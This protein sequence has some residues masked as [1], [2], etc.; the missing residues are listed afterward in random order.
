M[1]EGQDDRILVFKFF[2]SFHLCTCVLQ[3][4]SL[5]T[6]VG[7]GS[8]MYVFVVL[9][10]IF[11]GLSVLTSVLMLI[12]LCVEIRFLL[13]PWVISVALTT[14]LDVLLS[15]CII[16]DAINDT[17]TVIFFVVD[18]IVCALNIYC[19]LCVISQYQELTAGRGRSHTV[20][21]IQDRVAVQYRHDGKVGYMKP[22]QTNGPNS[23]V[24]LTVPTGLT[25]GSRQSTDMSSISEELLSSRR[26]STDETSVEYDRC[27]TAPLIKIRT[28]S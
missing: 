18:Y 19:L 27:P 14:L 5:G 22:G 13:L 23:S 4:S 24:L 15:F 9:L 7:H 3:F 26:I 16:A 25:V 1:D 28:P 8:V 12:G 17:V 2:Y 6:I 20:A 11:S 10:M 21:A